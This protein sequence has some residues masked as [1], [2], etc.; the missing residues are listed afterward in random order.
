MAVVDCHCHAGTGELLDAPWNTDAPL[1]P[2]L[3]RARAAG[4]ERTVVVPVFNTNSRRANRELA[5]IVA[6]AGGRL[7]GFAWIHPRRDARR[8]EA[9]VGEARRLGLRGIKVHAHDALPTREICE[10]ARRHRMPVLVDVGGRAH[11]IEMFATRYPEV[12]F[13]VAHL[14][15][16]AD[17]WRA[18]L[19]VIDCLV[20]H[21][22]VYADTSGVRRF[23]Y[24]MEAVRRAGPRKLLFGSD[25][26]WLHP[27][28][29][30]HKIR[31]LGLAP[32]GER[33]IAG[34]NLM[35][36][37]R[38]RSAAPSRRSA[39]RARRAPSPASG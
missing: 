29:E 16:F 17:D 33:L 14:G 18:H 37:L 11:S 1:G 5:G 32:A 34:G 28:L 7:I 39:R 10:A 23:D 30:L 2:Y 26:P 38:E 4:I 31:L 27:G 6:R 36:I 15:S 13:V 35:R 25:G 19:T 22:N 21:P 3:R 8:A 9:L 20:R 24:L 12:P